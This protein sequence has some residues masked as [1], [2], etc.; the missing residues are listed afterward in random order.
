M[1]LVSEQDAGVH[2]ALVGELVAAGAL[3]ALAKVDGVAEGDDVGVA[4]GPAL[5]EGPR[6]GDVEDDG[7]VRALLLGLLDD[8]GEVG[9]GEDVKVARGE[10]GGP[11]VEDLDGLLRSGRRWGVVIGGESSY[12]AS[13]EY[14]IHTWAPLSAW[15]LI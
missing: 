3:D 6:V 2:V 10:L 15:Y 9:A 8:V 7:Q 11:R 13:G 12:V 1:L 5:D 14:R 4:L